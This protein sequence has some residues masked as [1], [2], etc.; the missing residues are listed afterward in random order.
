MVR[1]TFYPEIV[2]DDLEV[3][4][5]HAVLLT[6]DGRVLLRYK[7][8]EA[9][10]VGGRPEEFDGSLEETL[11][12]EVLEEANCEIDKIDYIGYQKVL[13]D[14][15]PYAQVR[16]VARLS[17]IGPALPDPDRSGNWIYGRTL[18]P[19]EIAYQELTKSFGE[20]GE[21]LLAHA[22]KTAQAKNYFTEPLSI[23]YEVINVESR[24]A[25]A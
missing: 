1:Y 11:R 22:L 12:R 25:L 13:G 21:R 15:R 20:I 8:S 24:D 4:Q 19:R 18:A 6:R 14:G 2:P 5:V 7:N 10:L 9:R 17:K 3:T 23:E 16:M